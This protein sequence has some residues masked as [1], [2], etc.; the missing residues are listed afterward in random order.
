MTMTDPI[1]DML[2]RIRNANTAS[3]DSVDIPA[4]KQKLAIVAIMKDE[5]YIEDFELITDP[6]GDT[7]RVTLKYQ[8]DRS[9]TIHGIKRV[10]KPGLRV[11]T[12][13]GQLPKVLGGLGVAIVS[14]SAG[15]MTGRKAA[16]RKLGGEVVAHIW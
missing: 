1:A 14:T 3:H 16:Q 8:Q 2:S 7:I 13:A 9:K 12:K 6:P 10:S 11:Y 5:G 4:S 15:L